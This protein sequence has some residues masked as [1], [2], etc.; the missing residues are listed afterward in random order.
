M[1]RHTIV[2]AEEK[3]SIQRLVKK[4]I[5]TKPIGQEKIETVHAVSTESAFLAT[6]NHYPSII[7]LSTTFPGKS[8]QDMLAEITE[9]LPNTK[10]ISLTHKYGDRSSLE[11]GAFDSVDK[12]IRN[13][14]LWKVLDS[15]IEAADTYIS[16][17]VRPVTAVAN[18][19]IE[20]TTPEPVLEPQEPTP[21]REVVQPVVASPIA[22]STKDASQNLFMSSNEEDDDDDDDD[23]FGDDLPP[24]RVAPVVAV[25]VPLFEPEKEE[26]EM[27]VEEPERAAV[28]D[29]PLESDLFDFDAHEE[30]MD[31]REYQEETTEPELEPELE[32]EPEEDGD[33]FDLSLENTDSASDDDSFA[34]DF[35]L[36]EEEEAE[37]SFA[38]EPM[39]LNDVDLPTLLE[40]EVTQPTPVAIQKSELSPKN[41]PKRVPKP[42]PVNL[43]PPSD[44]IEPKEEIITEPAIYNEL[45]E[46]TLANE[47]FTTKKGEFV[48]LAPP[49]E[50]MMKHSPSGGKANRANATK[51]MSNDTEGLFGSVRNRF[52]KK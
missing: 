41:A 51:T 27:E 8:H 45:S 26:E 6:L 33:L 48:P 23:L 24:K 16:T 47:G 7:L 32:P 3:E 28:A 17:S 12:P 34:V 25:D 40:E 50:L 43:E 39:P 22:P 35:N 4:A 9:R 2:L 36:T 5:L 10:V 15:T 31:E 18:V 1:S 38:F 29:L 13:P 37:P 11:H 19:D 44:T 52:K 42:E 21:L 14:V 20:E 30:E 46:W 49:R